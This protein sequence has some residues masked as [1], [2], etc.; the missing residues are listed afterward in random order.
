MK[1]LIAVI[2]LSF[3]LP[4]TH[5][6]SN[7]GLKTRWKIVL[8][9]GNAP[10]AF[11]TKYE[12]NPNQQ[13]FAN[14]MSNVETALALWN[15][16]SG[17]AFGWELQ[18][19]TTR[20][21][22][23][24]DNHSVISFNDQDNEINDGFVLAAAVA[25]FNDIFDTH[26]FD[27]ETFAT[28]LEMDIVFNDGVSF[29]PDAA[30]A[31]GETSI[32]AVALHE[33]GHAL[34][35]DHPDQAGQSVIA[36]MNSSIAPGVAIIGSGAPFLDDRNG[37]RYMY[38]D[39]V[40]SVYPEFTPSVTQ[41]YLPLSVAFNNTSVGGNV[42]A[43]VFG[44]G[45]TT[46]TSDPNYTYNTA[47][48][49]NVTLS[50]NGVTTPSQT[51][52]AAVLPTVDFGADQTLG[53]GPLI[54]TFENLSSG[55]ISGYTWDFGDATFSTDVSPV[56]EYLYTG[57][58][59]V[60]LIAVGEAGPVEVIKDAF[61]VVESGGNDGNDKNAFQEFMADLGCNC[62]MTPAGSRSS[63]P[64]GAMLLALLGGALFLVRRRRP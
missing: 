46:T 39:T 12:M 36:V 56:H 17:S 31:G 30:L 34:G 60:K 16:V 27:G 4:F 21:G 43:W 28:I 44:D 11:T 50:V 45:G 59:N 47:G 61:I 53:Q 40:P 38:T 23:N 25:Y 33:A 13:P 26:R 15:G 1:T 32:E 58:Y 62:S 52:R 22:F 51:I 19:T 3:V 6:T 29:G 55:N 10:S 64:V 41:G 8:D 63:R 2:G 35:L 42:Y 9:S 48:V 54:V 49:F 14:A 37:V 24:F 57:T 5:I 7:T 18:A 20:T